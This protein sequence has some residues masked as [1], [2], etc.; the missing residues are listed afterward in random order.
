VERLVADFD[1][2][3]GPATRRAI[4]WHVFK[5]GPLTRSL[6]ASTGPKWERRSA[7]LLTPLLRSLMA[8]TLRV[9]P[10]RSAR[11]IGRIEEIFAEETA[12]RLADGRRY[13]VG[14]RFT[15]ADLTF[16]ALAAPALMP[17]NFGFA[18]PPDAALPPAF[19]AWIERMRATPGGQFALRLFAEDRPPV[20]AQGRSDMS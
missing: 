6:L 14:D 18:L 19:L 5:N 9:E 1:R 10:E 12:A 8:R 3:L 2:R 16:A 7:R 20:R 17:P 15:A 11:S 4:Y 13:L